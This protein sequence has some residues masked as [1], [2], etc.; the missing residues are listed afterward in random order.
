VTVR[1]IGSFPEQIR[2]GAR[3]SWGR[4]GRRSDLRVAQVRGRGER[5]LVRFEEVAGVDAAR[6]LCG[7]DLRVAR[8][9]LKRPSAD[10][11]FDD[12]IVGCRCEMPDGAPLGTALG[13]ERHAGLCYLAV[14]HGGKRHLV[15]YTAPIVRG[16]SPAEKR[17]VLDPPAGLFEL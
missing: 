9:E 15:P 11:L 14:K 3:L 5:L 10:F 8:G 6:E 12:E 13:F 2:P 4:G 16:V 17:I 1:P 7:G